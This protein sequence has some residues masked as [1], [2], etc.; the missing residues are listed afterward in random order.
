MHSD[1]SSGPFLVQ[2]SGKAMTAKG[3]VI[4]SP[5]GSMQLCKYKS[6]KCSN[7]RATKRNGQLHTLCH[8]HRIRQNEHQRK[9]DRKHRMVS[10]ARRAKLGSIGLVMVSERLSR[11]NSMSSMSSDIVSDSDS[12]ASASPMD[13]STPGHHTS[14][15]YPE[16]HHAR[17]GLAP[18]HHHA[19]AYL[20]RRDSSG[21]AVGEQQP[22]VVGTPTGRLP[23]ISYLT[24]QVP[25]K[26][27]AF[28]TVNYSS[29]AASGSGS[30]SSSPTS[31]LNLPPGSF[32]KDTGVSQHASHS[33]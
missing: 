6:G 27:D 33:A 28:R 10:V 17:P 24:Q 11:R 5:R 21:S 29:A 30:A 26:L 16:D 9:S 18:T 2:T 22:F 15:E 8:F 1:A 3:D 13:C 31:L 25:G 7:P 32:L 20:S 23:P 19:A 14:F 4:A 12:V